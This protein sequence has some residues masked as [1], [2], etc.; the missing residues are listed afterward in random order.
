ML[1]RK[2]FPL[3]LYWK[4]YQAHFVILGIVYFN[5]S[6]EVEVMRK[7]EYNICKQW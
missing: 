2:E 4:H 7:V 5:I 1:D 6:L 3:D